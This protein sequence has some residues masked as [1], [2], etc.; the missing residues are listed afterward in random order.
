MPIIRANKYRTGRSHEIARV[1]AGIVGQNAAC[2]APPPE[3][4]IVGQGRNAVLALDRNQRGI[5]QNER[6]RRHK[7][8]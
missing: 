5:L 2:R 4:R 7:L 1:Q 6:L 8:P 3:N